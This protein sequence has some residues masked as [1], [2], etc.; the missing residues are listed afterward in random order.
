MQDITRTDNG[1]IL[2]HEVDFDRRIAVM[3]IVNR[4][5]DSF[6]DRGATVQLD[7][8]LAQAAAQVDEGADIIDV[9]GVRAGPGD[10]VD[11]ATELDRVIPDIPSRL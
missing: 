4:T 2:G 7:A 11:V 10:E 6:Y 3:G 8:A 9:G 1:H 5:P